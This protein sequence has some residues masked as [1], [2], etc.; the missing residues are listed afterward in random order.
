MPWI[1]DGIIR[2]NI[3][4]CKSFDKDKYERVLKSCCLIGDIRSFSSGDLTM[5]GEKGRVSLARALYT[6]ADI[7]LFDDSLT[8][9]DSTVATKILKR[10]I[11]NK[12]ILNNKT[13]LLVT[14]QILFLSLDFI[15]SWK[16]GLFNHLLTINKIKQS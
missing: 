15:R 4:F 14:H 13:R 12:R 11:S 16:Q 1:F 8:A 3:L 6:E 5:I 9:V 10:C 7:Y 2:E